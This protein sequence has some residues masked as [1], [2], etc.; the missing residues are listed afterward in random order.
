MS[1]IDDTLEVLRQMNTKTIYTME[2][3]RNKFELLEAVNYRLKDGWKCQGGI[4]IDKDD[5]IHQAMT[6]EVPIKEKD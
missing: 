4:G 6:K 5:Y 1:T 2:V 3:G